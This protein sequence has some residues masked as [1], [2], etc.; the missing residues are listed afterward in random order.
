MPQGLK[1]QVKAETDYAADKGHSE[2]EELRIQVKELADKIGRLGQNA[3]S[4]IHRNIGDVE[5]QIRD[6]PVQSPLAAAGIG[7]L[8]GA[9]F[10]R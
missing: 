3:L 9:L 10:I 7:F 8:I 4:D 1:N 5:Q 6:K 2:I